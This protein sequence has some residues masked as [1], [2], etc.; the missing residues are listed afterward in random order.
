MKKDYFQ[1]EVEGLE[2]DEA[3]LFNKGITYPALFTLN[4][5]FGSD[6]TSFRRRLLKVLK[7]FADERG[8]MPFF[9][10][11]ALQRKY[12]PDLEST[13]LFTGACH[14]AG[15]NIQTDFGVIE[16]QISKDKLFQTWINRNDT[17]V[18]Y[19]SQL[20]MCLCYGAAGLN[21]DAV[22][23]NILK[24]KFT[25]IDSLKS[26][27]LYYINPL[28]FVYFTLFIQDKGILPSS[29]IPLVQQFIE[30]YKPATDTEKDMIKKICIVL[31][32][33]DPN[34]LITLERKPIF[35]NG[36]RRHIEYFSRAV[37]DVLKNSANR[38]G[39]DLL[40]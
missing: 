6:R 21:V 40:K 16:K 1:M 20:I 14:F 33:G 38:E 17:P 5:F 2:D 32:L 25:N 4:S 18:D 10:S 39:I 31:G 13:A 30:T 37:E 3:I 11:P 29:Y 34:H 27:D 23:E 7:G 8:M 19:T 26:R 22:F 35:T 12:S 24:Q 36:H 15:E 9:I 28:L